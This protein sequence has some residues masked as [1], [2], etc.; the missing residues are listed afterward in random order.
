MRNRG[1]QERGQLRGSFQLGEMFY[2]EL[3]QGPSF[4]MRQELQIEVATFAS[5]LREQ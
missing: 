4:E 5:P 2:V 1:A 3:M